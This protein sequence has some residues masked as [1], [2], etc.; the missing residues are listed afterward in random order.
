MI[1]IVDNCE[2]EKKVEDYLNNNDFKNPIYVVGYSGIGKTSIVRNVFER[3]GIKII[4][5]TSGSFIENSPSD[6]AN[7]FTW[8]TKAMQE[9][10]LNLAGFDTDGFPTIVEIT[11]DYEGEARPFYRQSPNCDWL[12]YRLTVDDWIKWAK[13]SR[14]IE[15]F[16]INMIENNPNM[17]DDKQQRDKK[18]KEEINSS[19]SACKDAIEA[20]RVDDIINN[21]EHAFSALKV[22]TLLDD[23]IKEY[24]LPVIEGCTK[25][26]KSLSASEQE[27]IF[28][29]VV[30]NVQR[31]LGYNI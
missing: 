15:P 30:M 27:R 31:F 29:K 14:A 13:D 20:K 24:V 2:L 12:L 18:I 11:V 26:V 25:I 22:L 8:N 17:W 21:F 16:L 10:G 5:D 4:K 19:I 7:V 6:Q 23:E 1:Y 28:V 9:M 3:K